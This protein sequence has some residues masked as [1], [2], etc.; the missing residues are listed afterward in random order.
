MSDRILITEP[1][2]KLLETYRDYFES[3]GFEV[4]ATSDGSSCLEALVR[5]QPQ[6]WILEPD[7]PDD[8]GPKLLERVRQVPT[9]AA[10]PV[11]VLTRDDALQFEWP[12]RK[13]FTKPTPLVDVTRC[14]TE[15]LR[16]PDAATS[17]V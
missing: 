6:V 17:S 9:L 13:V 2:E 3:R 8:W 11:V 12:A 5:F 16:E 15:L 7:L 14:V 4:A 10:I 1:D